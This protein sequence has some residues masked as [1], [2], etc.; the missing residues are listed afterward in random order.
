MSLLHDDIPACATRAAS[1][2]RIEQQQERPEQNLFE[3]E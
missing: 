3:V 1:K 2:I